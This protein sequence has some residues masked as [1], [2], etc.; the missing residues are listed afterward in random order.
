MPTF[1]DQ[2]LPRLIQ[3]TKEVQDLAIK[4]GLTR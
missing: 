3:A 1:R 2:A 4:S